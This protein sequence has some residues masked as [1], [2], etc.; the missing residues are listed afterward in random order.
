LME[1]PNQYPPMMGLPELRQAGTD[2]ERRLFGID[3]EPSGVLITSGATEALSDALM[4]V[5]EPGDEVVVFD[6]CYD[7]Y[8]PLIKRAG[9]V[10]KVVPLS[11]PDWSFSDDA[12]DAA[13]SKK[14]KAILINNP[15]NPASKVFSR[16]ELERIAAKVIAHDAYAICDEVYEHLVFGEAVHIPL[17]T[18]PGMADR[19]VRIGSAGKT[20]SLTGW[21][22]GYIAGPDAL[23]EPMAK[24]HQFTTF[25]T[26]PHLQK[27]VAYGLGLPDAYY[28][29]LAADLAAKRDRL[30]DG[31]RAVG[32][33]TLPADGS[34]FLIADIAQLGLGSDVDAAQRMTIEAGVTTVPMSAFYQGNAPDHLLRF[35]FCKR[36]EVLDEAVARLTGWR[37]RG[38]KA[39]A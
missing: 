18:L 34:Y 38:F 33:P 12:L 37:E 6:P 17:G 11:P 15:H 2:S 21:K 8:V 23:I 1:G 14:T 9:G 20:F 25:T 28:R 16:A 19:A 13:F 29:D 26:P 5:V 10:A 3:R 32:L 24:A 22:V 4:A 35:C 31:L 36:D 7:C 39:A 30:A 27:A